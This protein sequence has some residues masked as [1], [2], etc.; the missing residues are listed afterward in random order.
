LELKEEFSLFKKEMLKIVFGLECQVQRLQEEN[1]A[2]KVKLSIYEHPKNS[3]NSS[4]APSQY[5]FRKTKSLRT[6]SNKA[7]GR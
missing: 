2:L 4:V 3:D 6:K 1:T 5:L 7:P